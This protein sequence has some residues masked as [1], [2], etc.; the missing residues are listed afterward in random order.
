MKKVILKENVWAWLA[1]LV[2]AV[3][4]F[5]GLLSFSGGL[6]ADKIARAD[7]PHFAVVQSNGSVS[8]DLS[9][10]DGVPVSGSNSYISGA[11]TV[12]ANGG[13]N[14]LSIGSETD[15]EIPF[16]ELGGGDTIS[17]NAS[18]VWQD[19]LVAFDVYG[20]GFVDGNTYDLHFVSVDGNVTADDS[21]IYGNYSLLPPDPVPPPHYHFVGWYYDEELTQP[22]DGG[23]ITDDTEFYAKFAIN[24]YSIVYVTN[25]DGLTLPLGLINALTVY[26]DRPELSVVGKVFS[27]W[28]YDEDLTVSFDSESVAEGNITLYAK[29]DVKM[30]T[31]S[32]MVNGSL[33]ASVTVPYGSKLQAAANILAEG[34]LYFTFASGVSGD[35]VIEDDTTVDGTVEK[36]LLR[37][38]KDW[39][40]DTLFTPI[41]DFFTA[42]WLWVVIGL[43]GVVVLFIIWRVVK[44]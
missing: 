1:V 15:F 17:N 33:Y 36:T 19:Y 14:D 4:V 11:F 42:N 22:Y 44:K 13:N 41:A 9:F 28:Y 7:S 38:V 29:W 23:E 12:L 5:A 31:V 40:N 21:F 37:T 16:S 2:F 32:F 20:F 10:P 8:V 34:G 43:S 35:S 18:F 25:I 6:G 3:T 27:G 26:G 39:F 30:C 24:V